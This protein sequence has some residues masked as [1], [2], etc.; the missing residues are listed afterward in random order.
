MT[1]WT[2]LGW[3]VCGVF[4]ERDVEINPGVVADGEL[5]LVFAG[6]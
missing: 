1:A 2:L 3:G 6:N 4:V 5:D